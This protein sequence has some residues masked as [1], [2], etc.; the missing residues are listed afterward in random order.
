M[1]KIRDNS[2]TKPAPCGVVYSSSVPGAGTRTTDSESVRER[3][4]VRETGSGAVVQP[5][6]HSPE[7]G[8]HTYP[9]FSAFKTCACSR[10]RTW[11]LP[12]RAALLE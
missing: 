9:Q 10:F 11:Q 4:R 7:V 2:R 1:Q 8:T 6:S 12:E 3:E 5:R